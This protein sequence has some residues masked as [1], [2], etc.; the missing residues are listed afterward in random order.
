MPKVRIDDVD[1]EELDDEFA[2]NVEKFSNVKR[3]K[4]RDEQNRYKNKK[5]NKGRVRSENN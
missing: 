1:I 4:M 2:E 3:T 5:Q